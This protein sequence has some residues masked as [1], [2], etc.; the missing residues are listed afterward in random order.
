MKI[1]TFGAAAILAAVTTSA[2][3]ARPSLEQIEACC[4]TQAETVKVEQY[5]KM[6]KTGAAATALGRRYAREDRDPS[7]KARALFWFRDAAEKGFPDAIMRVAIFTADDAIKPCFNEPA[8]AEARTWLS[9]PALQTPPWQNQA[10][11]WLTSIQ[12]ARAAVPS[13]STAA[14]SIP[15]S[16]PP[17]LLP[18]T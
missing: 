8:A 10:V 6:E 2:I 5:A 4:K 3:L 11:Q 14:S 9:H 12:T 16:K 7:D 1:I 13:C 17:L 18:S 15:A